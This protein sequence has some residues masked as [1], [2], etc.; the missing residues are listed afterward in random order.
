MELD[1]ENINF[2][3]FEEVRKQLKR[4][5]RYSLYKTMF[6]RT[7]VESHSQNVFTILKEL[8]PKIRKIYPKFDEEKALIMAAIHDDAEILIGDF[9]AGNKAKL[10]SKELEDLK[11][12]EL[13]AIEEIS[14][15]YPKSLNNQNYK[16][17][18]LEVVNMN[19]IESS[20]VKY[21]DR[22]DA[23]GESCHEV[24]SGNTDFTTHI[25]NKYGK[26]ELPTLYYIERFNNYEKNYPLIKELIESNQMPFIK[27][28]MDIKIVN[29]VKNK[30]PHTK[31]TLTASTNSLEYNYWKK[32]LIKHN[33]IDKLLNKIE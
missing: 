30:K 23:F 17:M 9:Q 31:Q 25:E 14:Q 20:V 6:Y 2:K 4:I 13:D 10:S 3:G 7:N 12:K 27:K 18:L 33:L 29:I 32:T 15:R 19:T 24:F 11:D 5:E 21:L 16:Q 8:V 22:F 1:Y 26:I 28:Y